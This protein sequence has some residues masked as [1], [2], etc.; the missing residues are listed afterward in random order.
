MSSYNRVIL[1]GNLTRDPEVKHLQGKS[2]VLSFSIGIN[3]KFRDLNGELQDRASFPNCVAWNNTAKFIERYFH[4]GDTIHLEGEIQTRSYKD[5]EGKSRYVTEVFVQRATFA[6]KS[7]QP[8]AASTGQRAYQPG[9]DYG[10]EYDYPGGDHPGFVD[11]P[12]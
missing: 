3:K 12:F 9:D 5:N 10:G 2:C 6:G 8:S 11:V 4:K 1:M 7:S